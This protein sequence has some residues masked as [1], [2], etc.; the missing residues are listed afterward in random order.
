MAS[1][2]WRT[3]QNVAICIVR[4]AIYPDG[5]AANARMAR[6]ARSSSSCDGRPLLSRT[7][8]CRA[9]RMTCPGRAMRWKRI[10]FIRHGTHRAS[11][12]RFMIVLSQQWREAV[13]VPIMR[14]RRTEQAMFE[15]FRHIPNRS[16]DLAVDR[17]AG[18]ARRRGVMRFV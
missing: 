2:R 16:R 13:G 17:V 3:P 9:W 14:R 7:I 11:A 8:N 1:S 15:S 4:G 12:K 10:A 5:A 6:R 18:A